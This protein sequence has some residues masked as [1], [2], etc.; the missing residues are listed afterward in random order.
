M[1]WYKPNPPI[2]E[3]DELTS[4][5]VKIK[6]HL[7]NVIKEFEAIH[8][9]LGFQPGVLDCMNFALAYTDTCLHHLAKYNPLTEEEKADIERQQAW[10]EENKEMRKQMIDAG[11]KVPSLLKEAELNG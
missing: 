5:Q 3:D 10:I 7:E 2:P 11:Y 4:E 9:I 8:E 6:R 1:E